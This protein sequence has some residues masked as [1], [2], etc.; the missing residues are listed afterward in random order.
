MPVGTATRTILQVGYA[1]IA[2]VVLPAAFAAME[3]FT[4]RSTREPAQG[5]TPA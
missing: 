2:K 1:V 5:P 4:R 3:D